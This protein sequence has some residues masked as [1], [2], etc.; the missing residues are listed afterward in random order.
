MRKGH[1]KFTKET[2]YFALF[3]FFFFLTLAIP[4]SAWGVGRDLRAR[5]KG[6]PKE[7]QPP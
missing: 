4:P 3:A 1:A 5:L 7:R 2:D 6:G